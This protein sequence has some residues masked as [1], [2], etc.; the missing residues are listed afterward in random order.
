MIERKL[1]AYGI[2][3]VV[4]DN[5]TLA[6]AYRTFHRSQQMREKFEEMAEEF[7][8]TEIEVP[9][10]LDVKVR[11]VL[12]EHDD[13]RWDDAVQIVLDDGQL[14]HVREKKQQE[15]KKSGDFTE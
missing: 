4:P 8:E 15:K 6:E 3:K 1:L 9:E 7:E 5:D 2:Q 14:D 11:A 13:L 12:D 10:D